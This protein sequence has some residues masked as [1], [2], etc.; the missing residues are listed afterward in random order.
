MLNA[1]HV[2]SVA[3]KL[4]L[5]KNEALLSLLPELTQV[6]GFPSR[7]RSVPSQS[8]EW[9]WEPPGVALWG[10]DRYLLPQE[11]GTTSGMDQAGSVEF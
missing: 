9:A 4:C 2:H 8:C 10:R 11:P 5:K 7:Q 6:L 3:Y 1:S